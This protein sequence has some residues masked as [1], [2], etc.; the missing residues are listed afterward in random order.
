MASGRPSA[1]MPAELVRHL[2]GGRLVIAA[3]I[4]DDGW[5]YTMVLNSALA[6]DAG[7][8]RFAIDHRTHSL[9]NLRANGRIM[10]EVIGDGLIYGVR[11]SARLAYALAITGHIGEA[12]TIVDDILRS[13][14][15]D[16]L[17]SF[18]LAIAHAGFGDA[19]AAFEWLERAYDQRDAFLHSIKA[20]AAFDGLHA[21]PRWAALLWRMG[22]SA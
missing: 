16:L 19:D 7:R 13:T 9:A 18:A 22:L 8:I 15:H 4:D 17:P 21:D 20:T 12:R 10:L 11:G 1:E 5:P 3:T 14:D 6:I 2:S